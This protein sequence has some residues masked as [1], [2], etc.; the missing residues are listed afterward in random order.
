MICSH[1]GQPI[2]E[3][4]GIGVT[5]DGAFVFVGG[6]Q[7]KLTE[8]EAKIV[9][10]VLDAPKTTPQLIHE[11]YSDDPDGG[12]LWPDAT[13]ATTICHINGKIR[14]HGVRIVCIEGQNS[15]GGALWNYGPAHRSTRYRPSSRRARRN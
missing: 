9:M 15:R 14:P 7:V 4:D 2:P 12:P 3:K 1:C 8:M 11:L 5:L 13:I 10:A 6:Q